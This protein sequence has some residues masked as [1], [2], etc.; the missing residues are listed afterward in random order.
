MQTKMQTFLPP[1]LAALSLW[2]AP[3][4]S[5]EPPP[6]DEPDVIA[7][8]RPDFTESAL[9]VR[10][11][12]LQ[13]ESGFTYLRGGGAYSFSGPEIL[14]RY[15]TGRRFEVRLGLPNVGRV[16]G[17]GQ[18]QTGVGATYLGFKY[19]VGPTR[20]GTEISVIPAVFAPT[21]GRGF[22]SGAWD[23]EVK[24]C[25]SRV[26]TERV[27]LSGMLYGAWPTLGGRRAF[28]LQQTLSLGYALGGRWGSFY[29]IVN[30]FPDRAASQHFFHAGITYL[31]NNN[32]Q[33]DFHTGFG[34]S[35][36]APDHLFAA[37]YSVRF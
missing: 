11:R 35:R 5:Q 10:P 26:F 3:A 12:A 19:Q 13:L 32:T 28:A 36:E 23:P 1:L 25:V 37:G 18:T 22:Q 20:D 6:A 15:G 30:T 21:G 31:I 24:L 16:R 4:R 9:V 2:A 14:L 27:A 29:E 7:T 34:L 33:L 17:G 8:D